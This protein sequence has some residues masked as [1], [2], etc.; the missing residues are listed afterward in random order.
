MKNKYGK[1]AQA[2]RPAFNLEEKGTNE[3]NI[4]FWRNK[5]AKIVNQASVFYRTM[6]F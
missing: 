5:T 3:R 2:L 6:S 1:A 4:K